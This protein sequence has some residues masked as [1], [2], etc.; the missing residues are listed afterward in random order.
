MS[1]PPPEYRVYRSRRGLLDRLRGEGGEGALRRLQRRRG[2]KGPDGPRPRRRLTLG[3]VLRYLVLAILAWIAI[4]AVAF[5]VSAQLQSGVDRRTERV[6]GAGGPRTSLLFGSTVL[7]LGSDARPAGS[8]EPGAGGPSRADSILLLRAGV[9]SVRRLSIL[10][11]SYAQIPG[12]GAQKINASYALGGPALTARTVEGFLGNELQINHVVEV[13]FDDFPKLIDAMGGV[14]VTLKRCVRSAPFGGR[15]FSLGRG[16]HRLNGRQAL[17]FARVRKNRCAPNENDAARAARQQQVLASMRSRLLSPLAFPRLPV[18]AWQAPRAVRTD[19]KGPG[20]AA[21]FTDLVTGGS[22]ET[23]VL[24]PSGEGPGGSLLVSEL[25][26]R[27]AVDAL[28][29]R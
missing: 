17:S 3:R 11:D 22:G 27:D 9:G 1:V 23:K 4:S 25:D 14:N 29:G 24:E 12:H 2:E 10:R 19:M 26:R 13:S 18:V 5:F 8:K 7:V 20:L 15:K 16:K 21:L 28:L 6:L